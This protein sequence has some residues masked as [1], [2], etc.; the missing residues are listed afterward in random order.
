[1]VVDT[2]RDAI[3]RLRHRSVD[4]LVTGTELADTDG[5]R[6]LQLVRSGRFCAPALPT[7]IIAAD[8][9]LPGIEPLAQE[10][11]AFA[12]AFGALD[13]LPDL[14]AA[15]V[16]G[17]AC[18][19]RKVLVIEDDESAADVARLSLR[20]HYDVDIA[21]DGET[22]LAVWSERRHHLVLLDL[23]LPGLR[24]TAVLQRMLQADPLQPV[25]IITAHAELAVHR[26]LML[27]GAVDFIVK[28]GHFSELRR[29]CERALRRH[30]Y[31]HQDVQLQA[32]AARREAISQRVWAANHY[33]DSGRTGLAAH[34]LKHALAASGDPPPSDD[35][36]AR[37]SP[38]RDES[39][40]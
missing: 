21:L 1:M 18:L 19:K 20:R 3:R 5:W 8:D 10:H 40:R 29:V 12:I 27:A 23:R 14:M 15:A 6:L 26:D 30:H 35:D 25:V 11:H 16:E 38:S 9:R 39:K 37:L 28:S 33:L 32:E 36:W 31:R 24:G 17:Y 22:G 2:A 34:H 4:L 7:V 13:R